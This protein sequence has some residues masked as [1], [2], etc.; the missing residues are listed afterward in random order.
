MR[1]LGPVV[2]A[3]VLALVAAAPAAAAPHAQAM[4]A[5]RPAPG[6]GVN[7]PRP[8]DTF[9]AAGT[10]YPGYTPYSRLGPILRSIARRS[11]RVTLQVFGHSAGGRPLYLAIV[12]KKWASVAAK[13]RW[14]DFVKLQLEDPQAALT[15]LDAGGDLRVPVFIDCSIH[16]NEPSGVDAGLRLLR[17][18]AFADDRATRRILAHDVV[19][20]SSCENPDGRVA[21]TRE[22]AAG[23]DLNR[24]FINQTQP[25]VQALVRQ[26]VKWH[27]T[28]FED[29]HGYYGFMLIDPSTAPH[30]PNY[31]WDLAIRNALP[32][33]RAEK[34]LVQSRTPVHV[35]IAYVDKPFVFEDYEAFYAPQAAMFYG[36]VGQTL[37]TSHEDTNGVR[38][39]YFAILAAAKYAAAHRSALLHDQLARYLRA[40]AGQ[41]QPASADMPADQLISYPYAYVIPVD[42]SLQ[43]D[44]LEARHAVRHLL[45]DDIRVFQAQTPF[46]LA[47]SDG[48]ATYPAGTYI[49]PLQQPLRG[50]AN[51]MLWRGQDI[52]SITD[53]I[54]DCC[55]WQLPESWG[56]D[57]VAAAEP[58]TADETPVSSA[59]DPDG[60]VQGAGPA[61]VLPDTSN[62]AVQAAN[63]LVA[64][65]LA[66]SRVT[67]AADGSPVDE[68]PLG[69][70]VV[71][72]SQAGE[73][74]TL[75]T[76]A[77]SSKVDFATADPS[78]STTQPV[79]QPKVAVFY[80]GPTSFALR[81][82]G[83]DATVVTS[84]TH[85]DDFDVL[86]IDEADLTD[87][88]TATVK[89]WVQDGGTYIAN[90]AYGYLPGLLDVTVDG[91]PNWDWSDPASYNNAL[92]PTDYSPDSLVTAGLGA[93]G[94]TF[95]FA[96]AWFS[97]LAAGVQVDATYADPFVFAGWWT[98]TPP[99]TAA[100]GRPAIVHGFY[101]KGRV[102]YLGPMAT[103]RSG[104]EGS[105]RLLTNAILTGDLDDSPAP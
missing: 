61:Y 94:Y 22:N 101:G 27:P 68:L 38:A 86:V 6:A 95:G 35:K 91:G 5:E 62:N 100:A 93:S 88:R 53:E 39:H 48:G 21:D 69:A 10:P 89:T 63:A 17:R 67:G 7:P 51:V 55:A 40:E 30:D 18:L 36:L 66:V 65:G 13:R 42:P 15:V 23:F 71:D 79:G 77:A 3:L 49:V 8:A 20:F 29:L 26:L 105:Y 1:R 31:E 46:S 87:A 2:L 43:S 16:G 52:S 41:S 28:V 50:L 33:A 54:Y 44:P 59:A 75:A 80:D 82:L 104:T 60:T 56:F 45:S 73:Q 12:Q 90:G 78:G 84:L 81:Q 64:D 58:F 57:R 98:G 37:E 99:A 11:P 76:V 72:A 14:L 70:F 96:P 85:L 4:P 25:E 24:D 102:T 47:A 9:G 103:F 92:A 32:M 83:F 19:I 97:D 74:A 34:A